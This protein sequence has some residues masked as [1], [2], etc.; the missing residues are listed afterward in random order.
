MP[1]DQRSPN[2]HER[3]SKNYDESLAKQFRLDGILKDLSEGRGEPIDPIPDYEVFDEEE[4]EDDADEED[5][6]S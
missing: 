4:I 3:T 2:L 1:I 6:L 5:G